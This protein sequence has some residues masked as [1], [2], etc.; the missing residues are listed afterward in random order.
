MLIQLF[1]SCFL[2][3]FFTLVSMSATFKTS[4]SYH[5][6]LNTLLQ[7]LQTLTLQMSLFNFGHQTRG[8][9]MAIDPNPYSTHIAHSFNYHAQTS[10]RCVSHIHVHIHSHSCSTSMLVSLFLEVMHLLINVV[11]GHSSSVALTEQITGSNNICS[12][13]VRCRS[14]FPLD[15]LGALS[16]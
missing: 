4:K 13:Y 14:H 6:S 2:N 8:N 7:G 12:Q 1:Q 9:Y 15:S 5:C 3:L 10:F 11:C 16:P